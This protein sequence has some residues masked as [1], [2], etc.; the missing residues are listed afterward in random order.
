M[1]RTLSPTTR[2]SSRDRH[3]ELN[4]RITKY[5]VFETLWLANARVHENTRERYSRTRFDFFLHTRPFHLI[6]PTVHGFFSLVKAGSI[7][8][9]YLNST[10][11]TP[12]R[13]SSEATT[14]TWL[15]AHT[16]RTFS[17]AHTRCPCSNSARQL[18]AASRSKTS[19]TRGH[20]MLCVCDPPLQT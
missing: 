4:C 8:Q 7:Y 18:T 11:A 2:M 5:T 14:L 1:Y 13:S 16:T 3:G 15:T 6:A 10:E 12:Q 17:V 20:K 9:M 19:H